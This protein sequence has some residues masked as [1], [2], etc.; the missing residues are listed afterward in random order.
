MELERR[1]RKVTRYHLTLFVLPMLSLIYYGWWTAPSLEQRPDNPLRVSPMAL[2]G[3]IRARGGEPLA[4]S[5]GEERLYPLH[6]ASGPLVGYHLRGRNQSGLEAHLQTV[7]SPP[8]P[9]KSLWGALAMDRRRRRGEPPLKGPNVTVSLDAE[10]QR[11]LY[12]AFRPR[13]GALVVASASGEV[14]AAVSGPSF[15]PNHVRRDWN[16]LQSDPNSPLIERVGGGLYPVLRRDGGNL[17]GTDEVALERW[18][19]DNPFPRYP[20]ASPAL[21]VEQTL[22]V[23]P[24]MLLQMAAQRQGQ[25]ALEPR[26]VLAPAGFVEE[27]ERVVEPFAAP[28]PD[29]GEV[30]SRFELFVLQGPAFRDSPPFQVRLGRE[31]SGEERLAFALVV[32]GGSPSDVEELCAQLVAL[33]ESR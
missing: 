31:R 3:D 12:E 19:S 21:M 4:H 1:L 24:L 14:L 29:G 22:L 23:S 26:L 9:P 8:T 18:Q 20:G 25:P 16:S 5:L 28:Q 11:Q 17:L 2:R 6:E 30:R 7:L 10:L 32:E 15:D 33:L 27:A 13:S